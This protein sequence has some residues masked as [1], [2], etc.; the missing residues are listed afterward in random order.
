MVLAGAGEF[1]ISS[2]SD[3]SS[4]DELSSLGSDDA[5]LEE[6]MLMSEKFPNINIRVIFSV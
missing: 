6:A 4:E 3:D 2:E 5:S 1:S